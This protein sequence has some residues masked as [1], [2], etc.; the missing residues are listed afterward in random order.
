MRVKYCRL[1]QVTNQGKQKGQEGQKR[2]K[3]LFV[4]F[5]LLA[6]LLPICLRCQAGCEAI[7]T[8]R[9]IFAVR[10]FSQPIAHTINARRVM[11]NERLNLVWFALAV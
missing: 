10:S 2:Q 11:C 9:K 5:A 4:F 6:P 8:A 3:T 1:A 7:C